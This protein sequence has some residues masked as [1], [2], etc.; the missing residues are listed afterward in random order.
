MDSVDIFF[1][2]D[3]ANYR[4]HRP[5]PKTSIRTKYQDIL[6]LEQIKN[7]GTV[8][9]HGGE[10]FFKNKIK[11]YIAEASDNANIVLETN[12]SR[13]DADLLQR[14]EKLKVILKVDAFGPQQEYIRPG[15]QWIDIQNTIHTLCNKNIDFI[16]QPTLSVYNIVNIDRLEKYCKDNDY[17]L[18]KPILLQSPQELAPN[19][20]PHQLKLRVAFDYKW[21]LEGQSTGDPLNIINELDREWRSSIKAVMP[22]WETVFENLHWEQFE[23]LKEL[24]KE[25]EKYVG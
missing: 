11:K 9:F 13:F 23:Q 5:R 14:F 21:A 18:A 15:I 25:V 17:S 8:R 7:A 24:D 20:L 4:W 1:E 12:G 6:V 16:I 19:N 3:N 2:Q 22:E 10:P